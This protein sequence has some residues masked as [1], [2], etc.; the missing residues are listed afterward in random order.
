MGRLINVLVGLDE[1]LNSLFGGKPTETVSG[2]VGRALMK[3]PPPAW[4][5]IASSIID[6]AF[7]RGHCVFNAAVEQNRR[8][9]LKS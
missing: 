1:A 7:G 5:V 2:T 3:L 8:S 4:A 9:K 6:L